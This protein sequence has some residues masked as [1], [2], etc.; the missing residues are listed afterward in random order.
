MVLNRAGMGLHTPGPPDPPSCQ[1][2]GS[3]FASA[4]AMS[5]HNWP[6]RGNCFGF[7]LSCGAFL[8]HAY[9][10][11]N[12]HDPDEGQIVYLCFNPA[13]HVRVCTVPE[14]G[15]KEGK[16]WMSHPWRCSGPGWMGPWAA[17][18]AAHS[19]RVGTRPSLRSLPTQ[20][21]LWFCALS[22]GLSR[23]CFI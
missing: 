12:V 5:E 22:K 15:E 16:L 20:A 9:I 13:I 11:C 4:P 3:L 1:G 18:A 21:I 17:W 19:R 14:S 6:K 2:R 10:I 23:S 7:R 8:H